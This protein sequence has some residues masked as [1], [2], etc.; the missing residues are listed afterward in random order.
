MKTSKKILALSVTASVLML[1]NS[2]ALTT[3][4]VQQVAQVKVASNTPVTLNVVNAPAVQAA[5]VGNGNTFEKEVTPL[6]REISKKRSALDIRKLDRELEKL[7]EDAAKAQAEKEKSALNLQITA[8]NAQAPMPTPKSTPTN[9][10]AQAMPSDVRVLMVYG[11]QQ[12]LYAKISM[13]KEGGYPIKKGDILPDGRLVTN[14]QANYIEV[15]SGNSKKAS[16]ER[17]FVTGPVDTSANA[18]APAPANFNGSSS[19]SMIPLTPSSALPPVSGPTSMVIL[20]K[21]VPSKN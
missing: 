5:P 18:A 19:N 21:V 16:V 12:N 7:D 3:P 2:Y 6:L 17:I 14:I 10:P 11:Y 9:L 13:G 4:P 1:N 15:K 8:Q 20:P